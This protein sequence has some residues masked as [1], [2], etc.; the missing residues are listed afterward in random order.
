MARIRLEAADNGVAHICGEGPGVGKR[1][2][3]ADSGRDEAD[4][5]FVVGEL[6]EDQRSMTLLDQFQDVRHSHL[7]SKLPKAHDP[8]LLGAL[9]G[10][11]LRPSELEIN[12][13]DR[14]WWQIL[15]HVS[16]PA[17]E[18]QHTVSVEQIGVDTYS[19]DRLTFGQ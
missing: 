13:D 17:P 11:S 3:V 7:R 2:Q 5:K 14:L 18:L 10:L 9:I 12:R 15:Q 19:E 4:T 8:L 6:R 16:L 1:V